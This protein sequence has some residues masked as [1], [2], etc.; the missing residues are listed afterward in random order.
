MTDPFL[1]VVGEAEPAQFDVV[2]V[3]GIT[4]DATDSWRFK[5]ATSDFFWPEHV[6]EIGAKVFTLQYASSYFDPKAAEFNLFELGKSVLEALILDG[7]GSRPLAFVGHSMGGLVI[8][9]TLR[10]AYGSTDIDK[11]ELA[12][13]TRL[14]SFIATPHKG[15]PLAKILTKYAGFAASPALTALSNQTGY[16]TDL[17][18][19]YRTQAK[20][21]SYSTLAYYEKHRTNGTLLVSE[22]DADP[23]VDG[24]ETQSIAADH[25]SIARPQSS[26]SQL[27]RSVSRHLT[28]CCS[29]H[30]SV[31]ASG[32]LTDYGTASPL[33]R[34]DLLQKLID[35]GREHEY[36]YAN[37]LQNRFAQRYA[38]L[39]LFSESKQLHDG[40]L[41]E[42]EQRFLMHVFHAK[43]CS[44]ASDD[45]VAEAIQAMVIDPLCSKF[46]SSTGVTPATILEAIYFLTQQCHLRW[47]KP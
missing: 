41:G 7:L 16:L 42:V 36:S 35:A 46:P 38:R 19:A 14:V 10:K 44:D 34:R 21:C 37:G 6:A 26:T 31:Q 43:I 15:A 28:K 27:Y 25:I 5:D 24:C 30:G 17:N 1:T 20:S 33:E 32:P 13:N 8:K 22:Q 40:L 3:H 9:E 12:K 45:Q 11:K 39:G 4:G 29:K 18:E 2:F 23:G 47:D